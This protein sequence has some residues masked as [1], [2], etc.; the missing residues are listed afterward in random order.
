LPKHLVFCSFL[1]LKLQFLFLLYTIDR[2]STVLI[3]DA[4]ISISEDIM[5]CDIEAIPGL[6][7]S[8]G[9]AALG[10]QDG[11]AAMTLE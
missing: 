8:S 7:L 5:Q 2:N 9:M 11:S 4:S 3:K 10:S 1:R 6:R